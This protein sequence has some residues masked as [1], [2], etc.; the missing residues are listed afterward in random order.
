MKKNALVAVRRTGNTFLYQT[1]APWCKER[2]QRHLKERRFIKEVLA[3]ENV[4]A[5]PLTRLFSLT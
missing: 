3:T 5:S 1:E 4:N 2:Y